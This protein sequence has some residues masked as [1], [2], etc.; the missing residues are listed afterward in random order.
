MTMKRYITKMLLLL[1]SLAVTV[2]NG[3][4]QNW[5]WSNHIT[6]TGNIFSKDI[7]HDSE[8]NVIVA[9]QMIGEAT[10]IETDPLV[11]ENAVANSPLLMKFSANG[12]LLWHVKIGNLD[13]VNLNSIT[14]D[15]E[16]NIYIAGGFNSASES[17]TFGSTD[18]NTISL[19]GV[20]QDTYIAKYN[21]N[22]KLLWAKN[23]ATSTALCRAEGLT[24]DSDN[25]ILINGF[26]RG[27]TGTTIDFGGG[28]TFNYIGVTNLG[29]AFLAK[30]NNSGDF[31]WARH[32]SGNNQVRGL[33]VVQATNEGSFAL[34]SIEGDFTIENTNPLISL[35]AGQLRWALVKIDNNGN[36]VWLRTVTPESVTTVVTPSL[37]SNTEG[38]LF[39]GG[40][41]SATAIF[42]NSDGLDEVSLTSKGSYDVFG[43]RY[44]KN[45]DLIWAKS[46]GG[47]TIDRAFGVAVN[48]NQ[49]S[50]YG[51]NTSI[52]YIE[53]DTIPIPTPTYGVYN[54]NLDYS[55]NLLSQTSLSP[56]ASFDRD[57]AIAIDE[58]GNSFIAGFF[59]STSI[60]IG[61]KT[62]TNGGGKDAFIAKHTNIHVLPQITQLNC[63]NGNDGAI[64]LTI[65][66]GAD[67]PYTYTF[68]KVNESIIDQGTY[69]STLTYS[70]LSN[71]IYAIDI[72]DASNRNITKFYSIDN[73]TPITI[74]ENI[75]HV[76]GC[77]ANQNGEIILTVSGGAD[78]YTFLWD[79][80]NGYGLTPLTKDQNSLTAGI[81]TVTVTDENGC[82][83][84]KTFEV[85]Q[86]DR[87]IFNQSTVINNT[88]NNPVTP[89]G[90]INLEVTNANLPIVTYTW[91]GP[92]GYTAD[93]QDLIELKGGTYNIRITDTNG[94]DADTSFHVVDENIFYI[95]ISDK[96]NPECRG[97][98]NGT[99]TVS[100]GNNE[101]TDG[102]TIE[103]SDG[104]T[105]LTATGL[106]AGI[107]SV[108]VTNNNSTPEPEDD[109]QFTTQ[110]VISEPDYPFSLSHIATPTTC[111]NDADGS[112]ILYTN[113]WYSPYTYD[114]TTDNGS[115]IV[116]GQK[117]Q[118][119]LTIGAYTVVATDVNGCERTRNIPINF[120]Y[121]EPVVTLSSPSG[122]TLCEGVPIDIIANG[123]ELYQFYINDMPQGSF[124]TNNTLTITEPIDGMRVKAVGMNTAGCTS[125]SEEIAL[126]VTPNVGVPT[127]TNGAITLCSGATATYTAAA[128]NAETIVYSIQSGTAV[129]NPSTGEVTNI[130]ADFTIR[131]TAYGYNGCGEEFTELAVTVNPIPEPVISTN[132]N[133]AVCSGDDINVE[134]T[135]NIQNAQ[136]YQWFKNGEVIAGANESSYTATAIGIYSLVVTENDCSGLSNEYEITQIIRPE[137]IISTN[138]PLNWTE[139]ESISVSFTVDIAAADAYQWLLN[140]NPITGATAD[141]Y[142]ASEA[143]IYS[144]EVTQLGCL[145]TSNSLEI[146]VEPIETFTVT[147]TVTNTSN[148][149]VEDAEITVAGY[150]PIV[151]DA[152]GEAAISLP[153]GIYTFEVSTDD[154]QLYSDGFEVNNAD[155]PVA[156]QLIGVGIN[157]NQLLTVNT[158]PN[159]F[160]NEIYITNAEL[161]KR[162][163]VLNITGQK[164]L[165]VNLD[166]ANRVNAQSI[167][168]GVYI[169][170]L[171]GHDDKTAIY[172]MIKE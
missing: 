154:Y 85:T 114:W 104:Q 38:N 170:R 88:N 102:I 75:I 96:N 89:N 81:Y 43:A 23:V 111:P 112:I 134:F 148:N 106:S 103:W 130:G 160:N 126:T 105:A 161:V 21:A 158:Y 5:D 152:S 33:S 47:T 165:G 49:F 14:L 29:N 17:C 149:A 117:N 136:A 51:Y 145:G 159:P 91:D 27:G 142:L 144:V 66:G 78:N 37:V 123:A 113:G 116:N 55:G 140:S 132:D 157:P 24:L 135:S 100:W 93:Y 7:V 97:G 46:F 19:S 163:I 42:T 99:A 26:F 153:N 137:P 166:G 150:D 156:V 155:L 11:S 62:L 57:G 70:N 108:T 95:W 13:A 115:G 58:N 9:V 10:I 64:S 80:E 4:P 143:G 39:I 92:N 107:Y 76:S 6:G 131:A 167:K 147:F 98:S 79:T 168:P 34:F 30:Y 87:I 121:P 151:T 84:N 1:F 125:E 128:D 20:G 35:P 120:S 90:Q 52:V 32:F 141:S 53:H 172:K 25:N 67:E 3:Y 44:N 41:V 8:G 127:F 77:Y 101:P 28:N 164:V 94:C 45:G 2:L 65:S 18:A 16:N 54:I 56:V 36:P 69:S 133:L 72:E 60:D 139:G 68:R 74:D 169:V 146:T 31:I 110:A 118:E 162:V 109:F 73:P 71:G 48:A 50:I 59:S 82:S 86:P 129:V 63:H 138:D 124:S 40:S 171:I 61:T 22:G 12:A 83:A 122:V 119:N 15:Y